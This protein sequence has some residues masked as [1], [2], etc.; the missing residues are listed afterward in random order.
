MN[1]LT[2]ILTGASVLA[3]A[4]LALA[5]DSLP[6]LA[7]LAPPPIPDDNLMSPEKV[8]LGEKLFWDGRLSGNGSMPCSACH[9][10]DLGWG[11]GGAISFGYPGSQHWRN[12]QAI[13]NSAYYNK[14]FW[15]GNATSLES[16][17][18]GAAGGAVAAVA[19]VVQRGVGVEG[20]A[21]DVVELH[22]TVILILVQRVHVH[23]VFQLLYQ[24]FHIVGRVA[25]SVAAAFL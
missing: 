25:Q 15:E 1:R 21:G 19:I 10:P 13:V 11:T 4:T 22:F 17:A 9:S 18:K 16:Q 2:A 3:M 23:L 12:S 8:A 5:Q 7:T 6:P 24:A 14:L 20:D